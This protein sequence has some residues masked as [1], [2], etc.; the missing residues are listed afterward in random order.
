MEPNNLPQILFFESLLPIRLWWMLSWNCA[1]NTLMALTDEHSVNVKYLNVANWTK[2]QEFIWKSRN[3]LSF[4]V[5]LLIPLRGRHT[6]NKKYAFLLIYENVFLWNVVS[7]SYP[8]WRLPVNVWYYVNFQWSDFLFF[9]TEN[10][11]LWSTILD[12]AVYWTFW[13]RHLN[14]FY[15]CSG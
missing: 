8:L 13:K 12:N 4:I 2:D 6:N 5:E 1:L 11:D 7:W 9:K 10:H 14:G 15:E 3:Y